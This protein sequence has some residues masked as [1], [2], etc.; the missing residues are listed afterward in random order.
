MSET[1]PKEF[2]CPV[3]SAHWVGIKDREEALTRIL[4]LQ[5]T[6]QDNQEYGMKGLEPQRCEKLL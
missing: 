6:Q 5:R 1:E 3:C 2:I 4:F